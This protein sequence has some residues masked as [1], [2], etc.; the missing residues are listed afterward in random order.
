MTKRATQEERVGSCFN[1]LIAMILRV[2]HQER[3]EREEAEAE[4]QS[5]LAA[6]A[7]EQLQEQLQADAQKH[8]IAKEMQYKAAR[9]R[10]QSDAT[11]VPSVGDILTE[12][13]PIEV[14]FR[15]IRFNAVK[16]FHSRKGL[17]VHFWAY[18]CALI[19]LYRVSGC[20]VPCR[21]FM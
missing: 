19:T 1:I 4:R 15:G 18:F 2:L 12:S 9:R 3:R 11:E 6:R 21:S 10:A 7:A 8:L 20:H 14:E 5:Q 17:L 13:F 16:M